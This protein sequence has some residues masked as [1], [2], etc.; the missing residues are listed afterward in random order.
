[1]QQIIQQLLSNQIKDIDALK[2]AKRAFASE[3][4]LASLPS[5][6]QLLKTYRD[7][8]AKKMITRDKQVEQLL[9]KRAI[10]SSS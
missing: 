8:L 5:N 1:M 4:K 3:K 2:E 10:R 9:K 7:M 6:I